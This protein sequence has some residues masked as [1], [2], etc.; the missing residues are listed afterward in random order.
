MESTEHSE[1]ELIFMGSIEGKS[2]EQ[3]AD[4]AWEAFQKWKKASRQEPF[5]PVLHLKPEPE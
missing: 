5:Q 1:R 3:L 2:P 4:E